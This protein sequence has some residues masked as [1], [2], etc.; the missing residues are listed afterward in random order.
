MLF[1]C[2]ILHL[3]SDSFLTMEYAQA[4]FSAVRVLIDSN[5]QIINRLRFWCLMYGL[6]LSPLME[7][8]GNADVWCKVHILLD[9]ENEDIDEFRKSQ[10][11]QCNMTALAVSIPEFNFNKPLFFNSTRSFS[12][13]HCLIGCCHL[14]TTTISRRNP[15]GGSCFMDL[16]PAFRLLC[17]VLRLQYA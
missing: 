8:F 15:L 16:Q 14:F 17:R 2:L 6:F 7:V 11:E 3:R 5:F 12:G 9:S 10:S 13:N 4:F 1:P